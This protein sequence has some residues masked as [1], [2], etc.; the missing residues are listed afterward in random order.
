L[1]NKNNKN[2]NIG[3]ENIKNNYGINLPYNQSQN[4]NQIPLFAGILLIIAGILAFLFW[5]QFFSIDVATLESL[6]DIS[7]F[8][9]INPSIS[10]EQIVGLLNTCAIIG[11][12]IGVFSILGG[13]L[14]LKRKLWAI[15]LVCSV[16]SLFSLGIF[17]LSS[18]L[19]FVAMILL[20]ISRKEFQ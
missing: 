14:S 13:V 16:I 10:A 4:K 20:I 15:A 18:I 17:L 11:C 2:S 6:I 1:N 7:Q 5:S 3:N 8:E 19:S 9:Q 12:I